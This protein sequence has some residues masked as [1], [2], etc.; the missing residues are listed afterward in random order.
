MRNL[1]IALAAAF[2]ATHLAA[3]TAT[4]SESMS[5]TKDCT[6]FRFNLDP[7]LK[8]F[9]TSAKPLRASANAQGAPQASTATLYDVQ[10]APQA[11][12]KFVAEPGKITVNDG[13]YAGVL[14]YT[15]VKD[16][17][18]RVTVNEAVWLDVI[19]KGA[20]LRSTAH[21]GSANCG[22]L[23]KSVQFDVK[24]GVPLIVQLSGSTIASVKV[25]LTQP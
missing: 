2:I 19:E 12:V 10:L 17:E 23:R 9:A 15:P 14:N 25:A 16:G 1:Y 18:L 21:T 3:G 13:S 7:E 4:A 20:P 11:D 8:L 22:L 5:A 24:K 6:G